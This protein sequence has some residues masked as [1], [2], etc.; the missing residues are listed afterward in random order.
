MFQLASND[1]KISKLFVFSL[2]NDSSGAGL[3]ANTLSEPEPRKV[4]VTADNVENIKRQVGDIARGLEAHENDDKVMF[5]EVLEQKENFV[6]TDNLLRKEVTREPESDEVTASQKSSATPANVDELKK[7]KGQ[8]CQAN[9]EMTG[10]VVESE[11]TTESDK[12]RSHCNEEVIEVAMVCTTPSEQTVI[13]MTNDHVGKGFQ[14]KKGEQ[15][16][17]LNSP[18]NVQKTTEGKNPCGNEKFKENN[19]LDDRSNEEKSPGSMKQ[20]E[21]NEEKIKKD[22]TF[23]DAGK[24]ETFG[25]AGASVSEGRGEQNCFKGPLASGD[26]SLNA[27]G[28]VADVPEEKKL[29]GNEKSEE[30]NKIDEQSNVKKSAGAVE[31]SE[32]ENTS[33]EN[34]R[35]KGDVENNEVT[36]ADSCSGDGPGGEKTLKEIAA[37]AGPL[38]FKDGE[39]T[40]MCKHVLLN[41]VVFF[42]ITRIMKTSYPGSFLRLPVEVHC[43]RDTVAKRYTEARTCSKMSVNPIVYF[44]RFKR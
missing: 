7:A 26:I 16:G 24:K 23:T 4:V 32:N 39:K 3:H 13:K 27:P 30:N 43:M 36:G 17:F 34:N 40:V 38:A 1:R 29:S 20:G 37:G 41:Y 19:Q 25:S 12:N 31:Q 15:V 42:G 5:T 35:S 2:G 14:V 44:L 21:N 8:E 18:E 10:N 11:I 9:L 33:A 22:G 28:E 6:M